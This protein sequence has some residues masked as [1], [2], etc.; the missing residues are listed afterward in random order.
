MNSSR[1]PTMYSWREAAMR[2]AAPVFMES[3][4]RSSFS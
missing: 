1:N 4:S 2:F 3:F